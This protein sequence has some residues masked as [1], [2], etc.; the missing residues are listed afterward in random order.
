M[1]KQLIVSWFLQ[2]ELRLHRMLIKWSEADLCS[3][4]RLLQEQSLPTTATVFSE[5]QKQK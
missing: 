3:T 5:I 1:Q 4:L 2:A